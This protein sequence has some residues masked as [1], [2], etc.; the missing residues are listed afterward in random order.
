VF[1]KNTSLET[2]SSDM[3]WLLAMVL[4]RTTI[5]PT[6]ILPAKGD[7]PVKLIATSR[8]SGCSD[9]AVKVIQVKG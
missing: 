3:T 7:F 8:I 6:S 9:T 5:T 2:D 1:F 4:Q